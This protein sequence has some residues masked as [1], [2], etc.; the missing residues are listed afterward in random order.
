MP[1]IIID[2]G[3][4]AGE[5]KGGLIMRTH[6]IVDKILTSHPHN[7]GTQR[8][9]CRRIAGQAV[10]NKDGIN[11]TSFYN[12]SMMKRSLNYDIDIYIRVSF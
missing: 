10:L 9:V 7:A 4:R 2:I 3:G 11:S 12:S 6:V 8:P 1:A 5:R